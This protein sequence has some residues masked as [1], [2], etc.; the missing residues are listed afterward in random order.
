MLDLFDRYFM[1]TVFAR[2]ILSGILGVVIG[3]ERERY[4]RPAGARTYALVCMGSALIMLISEY[5]YE[6]YPG[7]IDPTRLGA[8]VISGIGFLGAGTILK[9]GVTVRGLTTAAGLWVMSCI[10][11]ATGAGFYSGAV[12]ATV[13]IYFILLFLRKLIFSH[14]SRRNIHILT[15]NIEDAYGCITKEMEEQKCSVFSTEILSKHKDFTE[16]RVV[17]MM[18]KDQKRNEYIIERLRMYDCIETMYIE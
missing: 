18:H 8:Q 5:M 3:M 11:L 15:K 13:L 9:D 10:G 17:V 2:L 14:S 6:I 7:K 1:L 12:I 16:M 4:N